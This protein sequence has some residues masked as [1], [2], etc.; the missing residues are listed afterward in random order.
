MA[1]QSPA[2]A[3]DDAVSLLWPG[4]GCRTP[5]R[6]RFPG[7]THEFAPCPARRG[8]G[9]RSRLGQDGDLELDEVIRDGTGVAEANGDGLRGQLKGLRL[10]VRKERRYPGAQSRRTDADR[11]RPN[12]RRRLSR[13]HPGFGT[14]LSRR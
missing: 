12:S 13:D 1:L 2:T 14:L 9:C 5:V 8:G 6:T 7:G 4:N 3:L 10:T 11:L